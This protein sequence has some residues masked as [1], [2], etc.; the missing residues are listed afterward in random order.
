MIPT[1]DP[2]TMTPAERRAEVAFL[3]ASGYLRLLI[4]REKALELPAKPEALC[5]PPVDGRKSASSEKESA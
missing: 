1:R 5:A 3:L 4:A 2:S